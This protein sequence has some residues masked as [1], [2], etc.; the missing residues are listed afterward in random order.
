MAI[1]ETIAQLTDMQT[2]VEV[3]DDCSLPVRPFPGTDSY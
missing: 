2:L 1:V 3:F